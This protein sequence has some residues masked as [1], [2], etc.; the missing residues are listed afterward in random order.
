MTGRHTV[1]GRGDLVLPATARHPCGIDNTHV[2]LA[3]YPAAGL[4][5]VHPATTVARLLADLHHG[6][7]LGG[8]R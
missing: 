1:G 7:L 5:V 4:I 2:V 3:A 8:T 6:L